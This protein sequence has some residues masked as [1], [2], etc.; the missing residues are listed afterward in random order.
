MV[1]QGEPSSE[2]PLVAWL[3]L[4]EEIKR[5]ENG[6]NLLASFKDDPTGTR[7]ALVQWLNSHQDNLPPQFSTYIWGMVDKLV[8][9]ARAE[10]VVINPPSSV[11][12]DLKD[13]LQNI[14]RHPNWSDLERGAYYR[15]DV[16]HDKI[17]AL[18]AQERL[19]L[20]V[21]KPGHGKTAIARA[22]GYELL[23]DPQ[24][25]VVL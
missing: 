10:K 12:D 2:A 24:Q 22:I 19:C 13:V 3:A 25:T 16:E 11:F 7:D 6:R 4:E 14:H 18:L 15:R 5:T 23:K 20:I 21:G 9:I 1:P 17:H 8:Q